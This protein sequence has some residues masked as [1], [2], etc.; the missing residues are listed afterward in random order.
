[1]K[2]KVVLALA[3][4]AVSAAPACYTAPLGVEDKNAITGQ[5]ISTIREGRT[6]KDNLTE[7]FGEPEM[8]I[9]SED[10]WVC[11]YKDLNLNSLRVLLS[12]EGTVM[13]F[14]WSD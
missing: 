12:E 10:M 7:L 14:E 2:K 13:E 8:E 5:K 4:V 9:K 6:T 11:F 3:L 1:M